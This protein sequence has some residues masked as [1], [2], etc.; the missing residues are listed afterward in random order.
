VEVS[1]HFFADL[2]HD[3][4]SPLGL[5][6]GAAREL[7]GPPN[8]GRF[9]S[10]LWRGV[11]RIGH[12]ADR[13]S[14]LAELEEGS[15]GVQ[16]VPVDVATLVANSIASASEIES[17]RD[18]TIAFESGESLSAVVDGSRTEFAL[19]ELLLQ[20]VRNARRAIQI[21]ARPLDDAFLTLSIMDDGDP[22]PHP[23]QLFDRYADRFEVGRDPLVSSTARALL[24]LQGGTLEWEAGGWIIELPREIPKTT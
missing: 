2:A 4:R 6:D 7:V 19:V 24:E 17:R 23:A 18:V 20:G 12:F 16:A 14:L 5:V 21:D 9:E 10:L 22:P 3:L 11:R 13:M 1:T 15:I 8:G